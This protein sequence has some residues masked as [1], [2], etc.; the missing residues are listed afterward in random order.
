MNIKKYLKYLIVSVIVFCV[1]FIFIFFLALYPLKYKK[2]INFYAGLNNL[3]PSLVASIINTE[4][5]FNKNAKSS[6][7]AIGLMQLLP[8]TA[9]WVA[10]QNNIEYL[11][12]KLYNAEY[13]IQLGSIYLKYLINKFDCEN[14]AIIA[15]NAGEGI[16]S[17]WLNN[18][19]HSNDKKT[20][21][22]IPYKES[23]NYLNKVKSSIN[24]YKLRLCF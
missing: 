21:Y 7:G 18:E 11:E 24:I 12:E 22:N 10:E 17:A 13:N 5:S 14:T 16:V 19:K 23:E 20:L 3:S 4:S 6:K 1:V 15:Y 2:A 9:K 8:S